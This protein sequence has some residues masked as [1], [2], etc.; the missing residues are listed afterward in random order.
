MYPEERHEREVD[1]RINSSTRY[2]AVCG[3]PMRNEDIGGLS[4]NEDGVFDIICRKCRRHGHGID[5]EY[6]APYEW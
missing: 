6:M 1:N 5:S 3:R 4:L 2:C